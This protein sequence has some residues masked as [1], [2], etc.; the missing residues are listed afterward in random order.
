[1]NIMFM[2]V[3]HTM[4]VNPIRISSHAKMRFDRRLS[5]THKSEFLSLTKAARSKGLPIHA[6]NISN[7]NGCYKDKFNLTYP[8]FLALK[9]RVY[10]KS[11]ATKAYYYKGHI[12]VF[13]GKSSKTLT[14]VYP[15]NVSGY[16]GKEQPKF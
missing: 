2:E 8:E 15:I 16:E 4:P 3:F 12:F 14:T 11:N 10:F 1:M 9:N 5:I 6:L 7:Y 13:E